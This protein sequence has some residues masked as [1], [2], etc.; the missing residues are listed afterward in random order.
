MYIIAC[1]NTYVQ[2]CHLSILGPLYC[3]PHGIDLVHVHHN[4]CQLYLRQPLSL[5]ISRSTVLWTVNVFTLY[6]SVSN[7]SM[8]GPTGQCH[9]SSIRV[10]AYNTHVVTP[11]QHLSVS[12]HVTR[13]LIPSMCYCTLRCTVLLLSPSCSSMSAIICFSNIVPQTYPRTK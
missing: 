11:Q 8:S 5:M 1:V 7:M 2:Q 13:L 3:G 4:M 9:H 10:V 12:V 6:T